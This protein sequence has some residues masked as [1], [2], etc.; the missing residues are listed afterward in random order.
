MLSFNLS[1]HQLSLSVKFHIVMWN[2]FSSCISDV[3]ITKLYFTNNIFWSQI[4]VWAF[5]NHIVKNILDAVYEVV[6]K[7][8]EAFLSML[9]ASD[10][11]SVIVKHNDN[12][13]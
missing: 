8:L 12:F 1:T 4:L 10:D 7:E 13:L 3:I 2:I 9:K 6:I 5:W 11:S